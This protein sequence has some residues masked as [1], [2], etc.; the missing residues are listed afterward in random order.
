MHE[1]CKRI[2]KL[3]MEYKSK[4]G[5]RL[6][7]DNPDELY[8][9]FIGIVAGLPEDATGWPLSLCNTYFTA[10]V[11]PLQDKMN[12]DKFR[13]P[14]LHGLISKTIQLRALRVLRLAAVDSFNSMLDEEKRI[15]RLLATNNIARGS[16]Y[17]QESHSTGQ[18]DLNT[19]Q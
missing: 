17:L 2:V 15:R 14:A 3:R 11:V 7:T 10:L 16:H 4:I 6:I 19:S 13:M 9:K 18:Y 8:A 12:D 5:N 1:I